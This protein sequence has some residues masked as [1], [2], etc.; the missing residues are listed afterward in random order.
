MKF[1][2]IPLC[3]LLIAVFANSAFAGAA[4][5]NPDDLQRFQYKG[6][7]GTVVTFVRYEGVNWC[8]VDPATA[9]SSRDAV[10]KE[11]CFEAKFESYIGAL[12][13]KF[14]GVNGTVNFEDKI[15]RKL[16]P[17]LKPLDNVWVCGTLQPSKDGR[18]QEMTIVE[19]AKLQPDLLRFDAK[20]QTLLAAD[21]ISGL[22]DL[23]HRIEQST[24]NN[25]GFGNIEK[26]NELR[27]QCWQK[28]IELKEKKMPAND[29][30]AA[31]EI[32][33]L[34]RD[35]RKRN[36]SYR[37]WVLK[38]LEIN[39]DH[40]NAGRDAEQSFAM[41]RVGDRWI[42]RQENEEM[43]KRQKQ[44]TEI[45]TQQDIERKRKRAEQ[46]EREVSERTVKLLDCQ[47]ALRTND[48]AERVGALTSLGD[49]VK[50]CLDQNFGLA[51]VEILA[52]VND[53]AAIL[54][55]LDRAAKSEHRDVRELV[56]TSLAWRGSLQDTS[57]QSAYDVLASNL[58]TEKE[59]EPAQA[60]SK[61]LAEIATKGAI[62][63]LVSALDSNE[64]AVTD[65]M[66][67]GLKKAAKESLQ[68][69]EEWQKWWSTNKDRLK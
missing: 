57:S 48:P 36:A 20:R 60:A 54:P 11:V 6:P 9:L 47:S 10:Y 31:Y 68:T 53:D 41:I 35:L 17:E 69:R 8:E 3:A 61:A 28:A 62:G 56:Y 33:L 51:A 2:T 59:K 25:S 14:T 21:D 26:L 66:I 19:I 39:P 7:N 18:G 37:T 63:T 4:A 15:K 64:Q 16:A 22:I 45:A 43:I 55:G 40:A 32:A 50:N 42:T 27:D 65:V 13:L 58:K 44:E 29:A 34:Y 67:D 24:K 46:L 49:A 12:G 5:V 30:N 52:N 23:G 38:T 1:P